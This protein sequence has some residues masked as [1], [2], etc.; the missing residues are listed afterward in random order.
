MVQA[1]SQYSVVR[2]TVWHLIK[3]HG[4]CPQAGKVY[5]PVYRLVSRKVVLLPFGI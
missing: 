4:L 1:Y 5:A 2:S 3:V